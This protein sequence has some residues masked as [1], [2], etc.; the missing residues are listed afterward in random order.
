MQI[1]S[2]T[3]F[4][5]L[6][7]S[8]NLTRAAIGVRKQ[9]ISPAAP[10]QPRFIGGGCLTRFPATCAH[11]ASRSRPIVWIVNRTASPLP[12]GIWRTSAATPSRCGP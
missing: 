8:R 2:A 10:I 5:T 4:K 11:C 3:H 9:I 1:V 7:R 6:N 12:V